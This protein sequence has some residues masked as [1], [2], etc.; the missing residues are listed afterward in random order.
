MSVASL[1]FDDP[2]LIPGEYES[3][4]IKVNKKGQITYINDLNIISTD[5]LQAKY[6]DLSGNY[7]TDLAIYNSIIDPNTG[8]PFYDS[9]LDTMTNELNGMS[10]N[11][12][13]AQTDLETAI[14]TYSPFAYSEI[15][16][17]SNQLT[18]NPGLSTD[19]YWVFSNDT[20]TPS[21]Q[22]LQIIYSGFPVPEGTYLLSGFLTT[23]LAGGN[24]A[25]V[26]NAGSA[27]VLVVKSGSTTL[28]TFQSGR[29]GEFQQIN[30]FSRNQTSGQQFIT[31]AS[32]TFVDVYFY[33]SAGAVEGGPNY[34]DIPL[35]WIIQPY[36]VIGSGQ[37][38]PVGQLTP[39][40]FYKCLS[41]IKI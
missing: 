31:F 15:F 20:S 33:V 29:T 25:K 17:M 9:E 41:F 18:Q 13:T 37:N 40:Q 22:Q 24:S 34:V 12:T 7:Y 23:Q 2:C 14:S 39:T 26:D 16:L 21:Q 28:A 5:Q 38:N 10:S 35:G 8:L 3:P 1:A 32:K 4:Q 27:C 19:N 11:M 30:T 6:D 36:A